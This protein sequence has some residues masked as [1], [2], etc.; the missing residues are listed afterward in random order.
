M[1]TLNES[2]TSF[3]T[4]ALPTSTAAKIILVAST[5]TC[6]AYIIRVTSPAHL[7]RMIVS[8]LTTVEHSYMQVIESGTFIGEYAVLTE[9]LAR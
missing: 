1:S 9:R 4:A 5:I 6:T 7:T 8:A 2:C 3:L